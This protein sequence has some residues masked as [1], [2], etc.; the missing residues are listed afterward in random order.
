[1]KFPKTPAIVK[2]FARG[3]VWNIVTDKKEI[4]LTFDDGPVVGV[5]D[6]ILDVLKK[7]GANATFFCL[8]KQV[9]ANKELFQRI[10]LEGHAVGNHSYSHPNGWKTDNETYFE[11]IQKGQQLIHSNLFR[12]PYG[13]ISLSQ[14]KALKM[15]YKIIMWDVL[16]YDYDASVP[17]EKCIEN[18]VDNVENG[19]IVVFHD[20][21]KAKA[22]VLAA[23]PKVLEYLTAKGYSFKGLA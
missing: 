19:S 3:L 23:L 13:R 7:Y 4:Y 8:G 9:E 2:P 10:L 18:V 5:T 6:V 14:I 22:N 17:F 16:S 20:S 15:T 11:N 21:E 12:P 1:M